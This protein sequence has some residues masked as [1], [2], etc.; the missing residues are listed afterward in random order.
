MGR[1][2]IELLAGR[3]GLVDLIPLNLLVNLVDRVDLV[4]DLF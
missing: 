3:T 1:R 4:D 2:A